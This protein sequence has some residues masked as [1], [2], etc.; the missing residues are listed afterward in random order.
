MIL[1]IESNKRCYRN[2]IYSERYSDIAGSAVERMIG[3][4][5]DD[6]DGVGVWKCCYNWWDCY[7]F[8][9]MFGG[10]TLGREYVLHALLSPPRLSPDRFIMNDPVNEFLHAVHVRFDDCVPHGAAVVNASPAGTPA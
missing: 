7:H 3:G 5:D 8:H 4:M 9:S 10:A 1:Q 2:F 6:Y